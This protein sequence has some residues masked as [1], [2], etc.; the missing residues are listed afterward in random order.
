M[1]ALH[2]TCRTFDEHVETLIGDVLAIFKS[3]LISY[4]IYSKWF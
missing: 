2:E 3:I 4:Q 1:H